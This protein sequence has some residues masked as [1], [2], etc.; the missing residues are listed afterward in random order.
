M[1]CYVLLKSKLVK[2][3]REQNW[4]VARDYQISRFKSYTEEGTHYDL[5]HANWHIIFT[6]SFIRFIT[7]DQHTGHYYCRDNF[8]MTDE[9][10]ELTVYLANCRFDLVYKLMNKI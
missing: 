6:P 1:G 8:V 2:E 4:Y 10:I 5:H 7:D 3:I 9:V